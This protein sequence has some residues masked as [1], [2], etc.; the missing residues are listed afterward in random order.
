MDKKCG[1]LCVTTWAVRISNLKA[2][3]TLL[4]Y[5]ASME[6]LDLKGYNIFHVVMRASKDRMAMLSLLLNNY[7]PTSPVAPEHSLQ[8]PNST[9]I[10]NLKSTLL[11]GLFNH[12][13]HD[14]MTPMSLSAYRNFYTETEFL[15]SNHASPNLGHPI[16]L[17]IQ[18]NAHSILR[19]LLSNGAAT[20][21]RDSE[22]MTVL[23]LVACYGDLETLG[24]L[25]DFAGMRVGGD[26]KVGEGEMGNDGEK[27]DQEGM[28]MR[29]RGLG[30]SGEEVDKW[31]RTAMECFEGVRRETVVESE[32]VR[33][34]FEEG[35]RELLGIAGFDGNHK[36]NDI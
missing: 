27:G 11:I 36:I 31:G 28:G 5:G 3:E 8:E 32:V 29:R 21:I 4:R 26:G 13:A 2:I 19:L 30:L 20:D 17:S 25:R 10:P 15:L 34:C 16:V 7:N 35:L 23:H 33:G 22:D 9:E 12:K 14:N 24:I 6:T 18:R 1:E